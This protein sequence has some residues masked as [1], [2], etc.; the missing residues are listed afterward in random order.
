[1]GEFLTLHRNRA[2]GKYSKF[3]KYPEITK[4]TCNFNEIMLQIWTET[5]WFAVDFNPKDVMA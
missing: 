3:N 2:F 1:M 4:D 5:S